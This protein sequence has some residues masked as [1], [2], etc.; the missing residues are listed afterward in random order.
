MLICKGCIEIT[1]NHK[2][3]CY[4]QFCS[5]KVGQGLPCCVCY[6]S[7]ETNGGNL[8]K[9][10]ILTMVHSMIRTRTDIEALLDKIRQNCTV[11][12]D[13]HKKRFLYLK[14]YLNSYYL[15]PLLFLKAS[16]RFC[17]WVCSRICSKGTLS[18]W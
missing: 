2:S 15:V 4:Q 16:I 10:F 8:Y 18:R 14:E 17:L 3:S 5:S 13:Y 6:L 1:V 7:C 12:S 11:M 9:T